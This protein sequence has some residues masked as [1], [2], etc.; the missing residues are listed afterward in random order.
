MHNDIFEDQPTLQALCHRY[1][2]VH[3]F[4]VEVIQSGER[5]SFVTVDAG[6][7]GVLDVGQGGYLSYAH[8]AEVFNDAGLFIGMTDDKATMVNQVM[9]ATYG[10]DWQDRF[11][12]VHEED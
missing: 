7:D 1:K 12:I 3:Y 4:I 5:V 11:D 10:D 2:V 6:A 9:S 8:P